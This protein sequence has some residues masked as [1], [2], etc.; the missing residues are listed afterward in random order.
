M[1]PDN[2]GGQSKVKQQKDWNVEEDLGIFVEEPHGIF[3]Q[4]ALEFDLVGVEAEHHDQN[5]S[6]DDNQDGHH[7]C[8]SEPQGFTDYTGGKGEYCEED[9]EQSSQNKGDNGHVPGQAMC[10]GHSQQANTDC[11]EECVHECLF[12]AIMVEHSCD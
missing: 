11:D 9:K 7:N 6:Q 8:P 3:E 10:E 1:L 2:E 12:E 4:V 5:Y